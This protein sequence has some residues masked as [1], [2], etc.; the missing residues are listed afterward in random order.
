VTGYLH[1]FTTDKALVII[2]EA[3]DDWTTTNIAAYF[4]LEAPAYLPEG[5]SYSYTAPGPV[6]H[7]E[8]VIPLCDVPGSD[9]GSPF[10]LAARIGTAEDSWIQSETHYIAAQGCCCFDYTSYYSEEASSKFSFTS[11]SSKRFVQ[12]PD[13]IAA[14][15]AGLLHIT[16]ASVN[17]ISFEAD[18]NGFYTV[19]IGF[20]DSQTTPAAAAALLAT[21]DPAEFEKVG[22]V[23]ISVGG[24]TAETFSNEPEHAVPKHD[25]YSG[26]AMFIV[27]SVALVLILSS[28]FVFMLQ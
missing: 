26:S 11:A 16:P 22:L 20:T 5:L 13:E 24:V 12:D 21:L 7:I 10:F 19:E 28:V 27:P 1:A 4:G 3:I 2:W 6:G 15:I 17:V 14:A 23:K 8:M 25:F 18:E 9:C